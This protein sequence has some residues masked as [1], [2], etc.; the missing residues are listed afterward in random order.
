MPVIFTG[1]DVHHI[2]HVYLL[3]FGFSGDYAGT[4]SNHQNLV[5]GVLVVTTKIWSLVCLWKPV[6]A[7][8]LKLTTL[9]LKLSLL[10]AGIRVCLVRTT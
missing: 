9:E 10:P 5:A 8:F 4:K 7:P 3:L 6:V 1:F 2:A